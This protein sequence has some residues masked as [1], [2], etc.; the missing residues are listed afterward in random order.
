M[1]DSAII[2]KVLSRRVFDSRGN[3]TIETEIITKSGA[4]GRAISPS[5]ASTGKNEAVEIR[6]KDERYNG[7]DVKKG[8]DL[9]NNEITYNKVVIKIS[10]ELGAPDG[11]SIDKEGNLW[12]AHYGGHGVFCWNPKNG[13]I[14]KKIMLP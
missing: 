4:Y 3:P 1:K 8:L 14:L 2:D 6:D 12:I 10:K 7:K 13:K 11:M 5:G 9:I